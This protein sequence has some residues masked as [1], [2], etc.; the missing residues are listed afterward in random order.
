MRYTVRGRG[1][2]SIARKRALPTFALGCESPP[3][4]GLA[5]AG[6]VHRGGEYIPNT[7]IV[8]A[9]GLDLQRAADAWL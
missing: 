3:V 2:R 1:R 7:R 6:L 8:F 4:A 9:S 5:G